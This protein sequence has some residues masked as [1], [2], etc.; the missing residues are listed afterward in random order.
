MASVVVP[1][2]LVTI[3]IF[4][5]E[6]KLTNDDFP[7]FGFPTRETTKPCLIGFEIEE[8]FNSFL[9]I[10]IMFL[11]CSFILDNT[12]LGRSSS[13]KSINASVLAK[14]WVSFLLIFSTKI[15]SPPDKL[16]IA[17]LLCFSVS[18]FIKSD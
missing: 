4:L 1:G 18:E 14:S 2:I 8:F 17:K 10:C 5:F 16:F 15:E 11:F 9:I 7:V 3:E 12:F 13:E 6:M